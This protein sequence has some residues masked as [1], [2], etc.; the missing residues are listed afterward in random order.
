MA[1]ESAEMTSKKSKDTKEAKDSKEPQAANDRKSR[2]APAN[3]GVQPPIST[4]GGN[5][6]TFPMP[7]S[8]NK[9][10]IEFESKKSSATTD[11][12]QLQL[13]LEHIAW[14]R[15]DEAESLLKANKDLALAKVILR[16]ML[17]EPLGT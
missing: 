7:L 5:D 17:K 16:T 1:S 2:S 9:V 12:K 6:S 10:Q 13:L 4:I 11:T 3:V 15:Q 8:H 14:G